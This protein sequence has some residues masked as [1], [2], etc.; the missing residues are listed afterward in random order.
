M[1]TMAQI[2]L[3]L[4]LLTAVA[5]CTKNE[6]LNIEPKQATVN[7]PGSQNMTSGEHSSQQLS[8][9]E[10]VQVYYDF[11]SYAMQLKRVIDEPAYT[12]PSFKLQPGVLYV[13]D[14]RST[15]PGAQ[16]G[17][18]FTPVSSEKIED[19]ATMLWT[20]VLVRFTP[21]NTPHQYYNW[22]DL[23]AAANGAHPVVTLIPTGVVY[24][25]RLQAVGETK[26]PE[27]MK[28]MN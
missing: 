17:R 7:A 16:Q 5:S 3:A 18:G 13:Y 26:M 4:L 14:V 21:G 25:G 11:H 15:A 6:L 12:N 22:L 2:F 1:K 28:E 24:E 10:Q 20:K 23:A 19:G 27:S 8:G 9:I